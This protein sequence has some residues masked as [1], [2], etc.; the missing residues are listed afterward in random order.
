MDLLQPVLPRFCV[1]YSLTSHIEL[2]ETSSLWLGL[3]RTRTLGG[4]QLS[5]LFWEPGPGLKEPSC[6]AVSSTAFSCEYSLMSFVSVLI[7]WWIYIVAHDAYWTE[8]FLTLCK[9]PPG[10]R[11]NWHVQ[12][13]ASS[14]LCSLESTLLLTSAVSCVYRSDGF[15][16][17]TT[18]NTFR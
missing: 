3:L 9:Y 15:V 1:I 8:G 5:R 13:V 2:T 4:R 6:A 18:I 17:P 10:H 11:L 16:V 7:S 14:I 12:Q